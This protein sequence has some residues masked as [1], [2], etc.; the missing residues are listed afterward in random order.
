MWILPLYPFLND[1]SFQVL[2]MIN[3]SAYKIDLP[4]E[5]NVSASFKISY[6]SHFD[7]GEDLRK[8][9][10]LEGGNDENKGETIKESLQIA[11]G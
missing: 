11:I 9:P 1:A 6:L 7:V 3:D 5:Y 2:D 8:N 4:S 10:F